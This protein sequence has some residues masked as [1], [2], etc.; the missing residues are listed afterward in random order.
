MLNNF[1][2][3]K[4]I[5]YAASILAILFGGIYFL[6]LKTEK[7]VKSGL[8]SPV[9]K[10]ALGHDTKASANVASQQNK[11][12]KSKHSHSISPEL[13]LVGSEYVELSSSWFDKP[14]L[15]APQQFVAS[16]TPITVDASCS[17]R[18]EMAYPTLENSIRNSLGID[19]TQSVP[20]DALTQQVSQFWQ[21]DGWYYQFSATWEKDIPATYVL[22]HYRT[23]QADFQSA[24]ERIAVKTGGVIDALAMAAKIEEMTTDAEARGAKRGARLVHM[25]LGGVEGDSLQDLK[26]SNGRPVAWMFGY[27][28]CRLRS[29]G[30][31]FCKCVDPVNAS[32]EEHHDHKVVD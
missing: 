13:E 2:S 12:T 5:T 25:L 9:L 29:D 18:A 15:A 23:K 3:A 26:L 4:K 17:K 14:K 21:H 32:K 27:G 6:A 22:E 28:H 10:E 8:A 24:V 7:P 16:S 30:T 1:I 19:T 20:L 31:A 11:L